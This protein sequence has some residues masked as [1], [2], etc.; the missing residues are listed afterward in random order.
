MN[1]IPDNIPRQAEELEWAVHPL[2]KD[3]KK[4]VLLLL[5][6]VLVLISVYNCF[7]EIWFVALSLLFLAGSLKDFFLTIRYKLT[8]EGVHIIKPTGTVFRKWENVRSSYADKNGVLLSPFPG[9][10][11]LENFR[12][13]YVIF[14]DNRETVLEFIKSKMPHNS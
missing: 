12:G 8:S 1:I 14:N 10:S 5:I 7:R 3:L 11:V 9:K 4:S 13:V 6:I 2:K